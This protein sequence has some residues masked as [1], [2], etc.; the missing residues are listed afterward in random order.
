MFKDPWPCKVVKLH[1]IERML[2]T[3]KEFEDDPQI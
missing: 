1:Y 3:K 2:N